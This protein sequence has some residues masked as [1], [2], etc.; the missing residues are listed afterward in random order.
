MK[1][2]GG[3]KIGKRV[4]KTPGGCKIGKKK[5]VVKPKLK[6]K[7]VKR[8]RIRRSNTPQLL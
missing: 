8:R 4:K 7:I 5:K 6:F 3:C 1:A 2:K